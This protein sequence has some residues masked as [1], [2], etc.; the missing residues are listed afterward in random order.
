M[1]CVVRRIPSLCINHVCR[2]PSL[3][4]VVWSTSKTTYSRN[5]AASQRFYSEEYPRA[6]NRIFTREEVAKHNTEQSAWIIIHGKVYD[7]TKWR[8]EHPGG[9]VILKNI[10]GEST[11]DF[12]EV[13]HFTYVRDFMEQFCI[14]ELV[15][16][17]KKHR[18]IS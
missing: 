9:D 10:G 17:E 1:A 13:G 15:S 2:T 11:A 6:N 12:E 4:G 8:D 16:S 3:S 18:F 5:I 14:G 7:V